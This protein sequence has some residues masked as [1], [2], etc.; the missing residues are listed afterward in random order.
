[1]NHLNELDIV[2]VL[3]SIKNNKTTINSI[4]LPNEPGIYCI[5]LKVGSIL[6]ELDNNTDLI[7]IGKAEKSLNSRDYKTHFSSGKSGSSTVRRSLGALLK[8]EW[9]RIK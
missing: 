4:N 7:Y 6:G 1:L 8:K 9:G 5:F 3:S 2:A